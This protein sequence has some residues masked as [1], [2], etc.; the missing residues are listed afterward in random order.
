MKSVVDDSALSQWLG[1][2]WSVEGLELVKFRVGDE[3]GGLPVVLTAPHGGLPGC[4]AEVGLEVRREGRKLGDLYTMSLIMELDQALQERT[5]RQP[6]ITTALF[7]RKYIDLNRAPREAYPVGCEPARKHYDAYHSKANECIRAAMPAL[8]GR[9]MLLDLHGMAAY[10]DNIVLGTRSNTTCDCDMRSDT[11]VLAPHSGL[12]WHMHALLGNMVLPLPGDA[13]I[14]EY[15]GGHTV[16]RHGKGRCDAV[17]LEF[18]ASIRSDTVQRRAVVAVVAEAIVNT[19]FPMG[20]FLRT[21]GSRPEVRWSELAQDRVRDKLLLVNVTSPSDLLRR[22]NS[23]NID[24]ED[25]NQPPLSELTLTTI[26]KMLQRDAGGKSLRDVDGL[27]CPGR[28]QRALIMRYFMY[29]DAHTEPDVFVS[30]QDAAVV[31]FRAAEGGYG[32]P[33]EF[34]GL[35]ADQLQGR[36]ITIL[37]PPLA[38]LETRPR[39]SRLAKLDDAFAALRKTVVNATAADGKTYQAVMYY[40]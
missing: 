26:E 22:L 29:D 9:C 13:P 23:V 5:G 1:D 3:C 34:T 24:L 30:A 8:G 16:K 31:G 40:S 25:V 35:A 39:H 37:E 12:L 17:Q 33:C 19:L 4:G 2:L 21:V 32:G 18:G 36:L 28:K 14:Q 38:R 10:A 7:H 20:V 15:A 27:V 6:H 11:S